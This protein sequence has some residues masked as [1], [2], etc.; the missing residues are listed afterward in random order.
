[1][2]VS[3]IQLLL[4]ACALASAPTH[5]ADVAAGKAK[6]EEVCA[7]C[8]GDDGKGDDES[9]D[10]VKLTQKE[11]VTAMQ[12]F[13]SGKRNDPDKMAQ[14]MVRESKKLS[15]AEIANLAAYYQTLK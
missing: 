2:M 7:D 13:Q 10:I 1:M 11:F 14:K 15:A 6:A 8:H 5:A 9:P 3:R 4:A 12:E